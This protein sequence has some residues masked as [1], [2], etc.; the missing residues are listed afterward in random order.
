MPCADFWTWAVNNV[1]TYGKMRALFT[2]LFG[3]GT[4]L[5]SERTK[6]GALGPRTT[7]YRRMGWVLL[8]GLAH[9]VFFWFGDGL[10][11]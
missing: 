4:V 11:A 6:G 7:H 9:A 2:M 5:I 8:F 10:V 3:A 1:L